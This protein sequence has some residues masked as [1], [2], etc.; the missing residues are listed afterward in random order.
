MTIQE[1]YDKMG[2]DYGQVQQR[3]PSEKLIQR[4]I[5]M[6]LQDT[7]FAEL[8]QSM[9]EGKRDV[10]FRAAHTLKGVCANL[11]LNRLFASASQL[12]ELLRPETG[13]MPEGAASLLEAV[14]QDYELTV[15]TIQEYLNQAQ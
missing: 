4:F 9:A 6:F 5:A 15:N 3:L 13:E 11:S 2:G 12:T 10:A 7:S 14:K 1:C 8:C